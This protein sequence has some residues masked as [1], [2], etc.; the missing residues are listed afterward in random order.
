M[1]VC[2]CWKCHLIRLLN[3]VQGYQRCADHSIPDQTFIPQLHHQTWLQ[4]IDFTVETEKHKLNVL[5]TE[6]TWYQNGKKA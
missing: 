3:G 6:Q 1:S 5:H 4:I 2:L